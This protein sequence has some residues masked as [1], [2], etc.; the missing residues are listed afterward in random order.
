MNR[1]LMTGRG[2]T[3][4]V[5]LLAVLPL[6]FLGC[7]SSGQG[8]VNPDVNFGYMKRAAVLPFENLTR[9]D[10]AAE[11][12]HSVFLME[13]LDKDVL[14]LADAGETYAAM[15][16]L[17]LKGGSRLTPEQAVALGQKLEVDALFFGVVEEYGLSQV[18]RKRGPEVT[19]VFGLIETETGSVVWR[20]QANASGSSVLKKVFGGSASSLY[21]VS[22]DV[23]RKALRTLL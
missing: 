15:R 20:A 11:R 3:G 22:R 16:A 1:T 9:D 7:A 8:Y 6:G 2:T 5:L 12:L 10:L 18:D 14:K 23:V 13:L 21:D 17:G 19:A 4:A